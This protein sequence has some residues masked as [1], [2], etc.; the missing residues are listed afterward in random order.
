VLVLLSTFFPMPEMEIDEVERPAADVI[1][2][3]GGGSAH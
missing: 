2:F 3:D 1:H